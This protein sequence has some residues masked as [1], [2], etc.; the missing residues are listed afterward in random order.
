MSDG[1][2]AEGAP[3]EAGQPA[4]QTLLS[5]HKE[6]AMNT[7]STSMLKIELTPEQKQQIEQITGR[8][9]PAVKLNL[10]VLEARVAPALTNN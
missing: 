7:K 8:Q 1:S 2:R 5:E 10:E 6:N 4:R 3:D 9:V